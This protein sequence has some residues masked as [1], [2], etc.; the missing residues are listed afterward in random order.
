MISKTL[1]LELKEIIREDIGIELSDEQVEYVG[2]CYIR[3]FTI[4]LNNLH[5]KNDNEQSNTKSITR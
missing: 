5:Y 1:L 3:L 2:Y 4:L